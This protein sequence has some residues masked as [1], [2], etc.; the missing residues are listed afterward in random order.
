MFNNILVPL[1]GSK[2]GE[3]AIPF[4][5]QIILGAS[6]SRKIEI[7]LL[8][9]VQEEKDVV[10]GVM[11]AGVAHVPYTAAEK[12]EIKKSTTVYLDKI[13]ASFNKYSMVT[14]KT[15]VRF[16]SDIAGEILKVSDEL[17]V[18]LV[19]ISTH[20]RSGISRWAYGSVAD[21]ILRGGNT[22]VFMVRAS[23]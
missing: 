3:A 21:K 2:L 12:E 1:D 7:I 9:V 22:P 16:G 14:I 18:D 20:G 17:N 10:I 13:G 8:Q 23:K 6:E 5:D 4:I 15:V 19:A 11:D